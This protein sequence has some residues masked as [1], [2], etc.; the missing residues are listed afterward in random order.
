MFKRAF[1]LL[2]MLCLLAP[3]SAPAE[4]VPED[5]PLPELTPG[6][7]AAAKEPE[8]GGL[9]A[10]GGILYLVNREQ[11]GS[12][13]YQ[14]GDLRTP[15]VPTRKKNMEEKILLREEAAKALEDLFAAAKR[16][17]KYVLYAV[18]GFRSYGIQQILFNGKVSEV[19]RDRALL[20]VAPPG[21]SEH[22]LGLAMDVQSSNFLGLNQNFGDTEEGRWVAEN[23][24]R[25]GFIIRYKAQWREITGYADEPWHLR[26]L[27]RAHAMAVHALDIPYERYYEA[28]RGLP[29]YVLAGATDLLLK[30]LASQ[31]MEGRSSPAMERLLSAQTPAQ[32]EEALRAATLPYLPEGLDYQTALWA[33]YPT[34]KPTAGPRI[35][36]DE[37]THLSLVTGHAIAP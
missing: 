28:I 3:A 20:T 34:P 14:P 15:K 33:I 21:A 24:H 17:K 29:E 13:A 23:A 27:G 1:V 19:G 36:E 12:K 7:D 30:E 11:K 35:D 10:E 2:L 22:Q 31:S 18:S 16:E 5:I 9:L 6:P 26:Y 8:D 4:Y 32:Q 37:E 25:F